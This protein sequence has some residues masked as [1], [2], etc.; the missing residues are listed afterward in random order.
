MRVARTPDLRVGARPRSAT[1]GGRPPAASRA[2]ASSTSTRPRRK[3][4]GSSEI[5]KGHPRAR[6]TCEWTERPTRRTMTSAHHIPF[7]AA[8]AATA[9]FGGLSAQTEIRSFAGIQADGYAGSEIANAC[10][11]DGDGT[12]FLV[13]WLPWYVY[14]VDPAHRHLL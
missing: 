14:Y 12:E 4:V 7:H 13:V 5:V 3:G 10:D 11:L 9:L 2:R 8:L 1:A 6:R